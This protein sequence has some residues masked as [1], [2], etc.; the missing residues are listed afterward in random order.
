MIILKENKDSLLISVDFEQPNVV[1]EITE[2]ADKYLDERD[3]LF[4]LLESSGYIGMD[5][6]VVYNAGLTEAPVIGIGAHYVGDDGEPSDFDN[7]YY[8]QDYQASSFLEKLLEK[9]EVLFK[10][11][12]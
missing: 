2:I 5:H 9:G 10:K 4:E 11:H 12:K 1:E 6:H 7:I 8:Y 3:A